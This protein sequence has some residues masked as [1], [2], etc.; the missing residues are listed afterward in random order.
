MTQVTDTLSFFGVL[1]AADLAALVLYFVFPPFAPFIFWGMNGF[2]LGREYFQLVAMRRLGRTGAL[3]LRR[4]HGLQI[5]IAGLLMALPLTVPV[6]N[7][8]VPI[9][10]VATFTHLYHRLARKMTTE[11]KAI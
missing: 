7:L 8:I 1:V 2:L 11:P 5:W 4:R 9:L 10:G 6:L 3:K